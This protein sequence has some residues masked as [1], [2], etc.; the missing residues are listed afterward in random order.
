MTARAYALIRVKAGCYLLPSNDGATLWRIS[1]YTE[2]GDAAYELPGGGWRTIT[3][4]YWESSRMPMP[5]PHL[6]GGASDDEM[7]DW[8]WGDEWESYSFM[9]PTRQEAIADIEKTMA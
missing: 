4:T 5:A 9:H 6:L 3:G 1:S 2:H 7:L 8:L